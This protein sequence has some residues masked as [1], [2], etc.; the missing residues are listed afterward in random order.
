MIPYVNPGAVR[1]GCG[2]ELRATAGGAFG[3]PRMRIWTVGL[4]MVAVL[5]AG[6]GGGT[7]SSTDLG[8]DAAAATTCEEL[9]E[10][11]YAI[12]QEFINVFGD[13]PFEDWY[14][15]SP[16]LSPEMQ[17]GLDTWMQKA[18]KSAEASL[19]LGCEEGSEAERDTCVLMSQLD[20]LGDAGL[21]FMHDMVPC[22]LDPVDQA[23]VDEF[24]IS[25]Q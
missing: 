4:A 8:T 20:P 16:S 23:R 22:A 21:G 12:F 13:G 19:K 14:T 25:Q 18:G 24:L 2:G 3:R 9:D 17:A 1:I 5:A 6:C 15:N 10:I 7:E 11:D